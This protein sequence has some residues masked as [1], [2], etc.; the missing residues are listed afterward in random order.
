MGLTVV[1]WVVAPNSDKSRPFPKQVSKPSPAFV[2]SFCGFSFMFAE[3]ACC[4]LL[5]KVEED[6]MVEVEIDE[7]LAEEKVRRKNGGYQSIGAECQTDRNVRETQTVANTVSCGM[8]IN[9][10]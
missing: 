1:A 10:E 7:S 4:K 8:K 5:E 2:L 6:V 3:A 9:L